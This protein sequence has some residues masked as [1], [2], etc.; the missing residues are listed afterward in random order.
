MK[1]KS[2]EESEGKKKSSVGN[3]F[4]VDL[5]AIEKVCALGMNPAVAYMTLARFSDKTNRYTPAST[6][7]VETYT[8]LGRKRAGEAVEALEKAGLVRRVPRDG[9]RPFYELLSAPPASPPPSVKAL[10]YRKEQLSAVEREA[11]EMVER[12]ENPKGKWSAAAGRA[13]QKGWLDR[14]NYNAPFTIRTPPPPP[15]ETKP[16]MVWLPN[17]LVTSAA[18]EPSPVERIRKTSDPLA[19][20]LLVELY[21]EQSLTDDGG[22]DR[23]TIWHPFSSELLGT[24]SPYNVWAFSKDEKKY[25]RKTLSA[26]Y[27][28]SDPRRNAWDGI[29]LLEAV[30]LIQWRLQL[31]DALDGALMYPLGTMN[32]NELINP[33]EAVWIENEI[34]QAATRAGKALADLLG[35]QPPKEAIVVAVG[36][37]ILKPA[38][39]GIA[40]LRYRP[41]ITD[42]AK[43]YGQL[44]A[45][46]SKWVEGF[47]DLHQRALC[48]MKKA[49][50]S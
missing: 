25:C 26:P 3:F 1:K 16:K 21:S 34:G 5:H 38:M 7:A 4:G 22:I 20:R 39:I 37:E 9:A 33:S 31:F 35:K 18:N 30:G 24:V 44:V 41:K 19:L 29:D 42:T 15:P 17:E 11:F 27:A 45:N 8:A 46:R 49:V 50:N 36:R 23:R 48:S 14:Q 2:S 13:Q 12:G 47:T 43:W 6:N 32:P 40:R 10:D 28:T